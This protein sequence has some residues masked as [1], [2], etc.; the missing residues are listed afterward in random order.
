MTLTPLAEMQQHA[1][2]ALGPDEAYLAAMRIGDPDIGRPSRDPMI[3]LV[4]GGIAAARRQP[5]VMRTAIVAVPLTGAIVGITADRVL[6]FA[7]GARIGPTEL[8]GTADRADVTL[9]TETFRA[10]LVHRVRVR[11]YTGGELFVD[12]S[13]RASSNPD[14]ASIRAL[15][16]PVDVP[17]T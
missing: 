10:S 8:L 1:G 13:I 17:A 2:A 5:L 15:I 11:L 6:V 16:P 9:D 4:V 7:L 3:G 14:L 12:A